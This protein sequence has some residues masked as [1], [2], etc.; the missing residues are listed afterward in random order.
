MPRFS[1]FAS[2]CGQEFFQGFETERAR[3]EIQ[4]AGRKKEYESRSKEGERGGE[5]S[6]QQTV[7]EIPKQGKG[8]NG[9]KMG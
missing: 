5:E 3:Y 7:G 4:G 8:E 2:F 9:E 6:R 1:S